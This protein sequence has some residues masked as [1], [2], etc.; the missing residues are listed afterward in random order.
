MKQGMTLFIYKKDKLISDSLSFVNDKEVLFR[1]QKRLTYAYF[2]NLIPG[3][4]NR[5]M[6]VFGPWLKKISVKRTCRIT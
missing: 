2:L 6:L 4:I 1:F 3:I 5:E